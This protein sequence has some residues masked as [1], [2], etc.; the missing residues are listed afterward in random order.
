M[1]RR[2]SSLAD[3]IGAFIV[4]MFLLIFVFGGMSGGRVVDLLTIFFVMILFGGLFL[5]AAFQVAQGNTDRRAAI[6]QRRRNRVQ[7]GTATPDADQVMVRQ[8]DPRSVVLNAM[9]NAGVNP[10]DWQ[11]QLHDIGMLAYHGDTTPDVCRTRPIPAT[12]SHLRPFVV[13]D[14]PVAEAT[15]TI[16]FDLIDQYG[17]MHFTCEDKYRLRQGQN[18]VTSKN[19]L[20]VKDHRGEGEWSM[21]LIIGG[22]LLAAHYFKMPTEYDAT[23]IEGSIYADGE[24]SEKII[25]RAR[26]DKSGMLSLDELLADQTPLEFKEEL[27]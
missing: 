14:L 19:W 13:V 27:R 18:F 17:E 10:R 12:T 15:G 21:R 26:T 25:K 9:I 22:R 5:Y 4:V 7:S 11:L 8:S 23:T 20:P 6:E 24:I 3:G 16:R 1:N 2:S